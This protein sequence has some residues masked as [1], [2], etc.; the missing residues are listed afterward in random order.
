MGQTENKEQCERTMPIYVYNHIIDICIITLN[1]EKP[2]TSI[3]RQRLLIGFKK[4][5]KNQALM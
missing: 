4:K 2:N 1:E 3:K 5:L